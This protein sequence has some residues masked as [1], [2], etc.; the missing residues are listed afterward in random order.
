MNVV[1]PQRTTLAKQV[2]D[3]I[4]DLIDDSGLREGDAL[5]GTAELAERFNVSIP[6]VREA[7]AGLAAIGVLK[8]QQGRESVVSTPEAGHLSR[9]LKFR[10]A[11]A[12]VDVAS[13]QQYR[14]VVEI[15][16]AR[17][18]A[19]HRDDAGM[20]LLEAAHARHA[21]AG[22]ESDF[23]DADVAFHSAVAHIG[24]NDLLI[25]T[26][27]AIS[28]LLR[29]LRETV[30]EGWVATGG[31]RASIVAAHAA[32]LEAIRAGDPDRAAEAMAEHLKQARTG[33]EAEERT[34]GLHAPRS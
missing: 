18:A 15:G 33:L 26:L 31:D 10:I 24:G 32:I 21:T 19:L 8:R 16:S 23:H 2:S 14:E 22:P 7:I 27:D 9:L 6:V 28:P 12:K 5:P 17:L 20:T 30:W 3:A 29:Q 4:I 1:L 11:H 34:S 13:I 25:L